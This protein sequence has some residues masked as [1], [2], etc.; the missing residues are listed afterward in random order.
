VP[1]CNGLSFAALCCRL[2]VRQTS[3]FET[4]GYNA[5]TRAQGKLVLHVRMPL[6]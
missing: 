4:T 2:A 3:P 5:R 1:P 6:Q